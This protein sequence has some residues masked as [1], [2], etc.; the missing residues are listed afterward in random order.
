MFLPFHT[1][2]VSVAYVKE[3]SNAYGIP[4]NNFT[5]TI[6]KGTVIE[7]IEEVDPPESLLPPPTRLTLTMFEYFEHQLEGS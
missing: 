3:S 5:W 7:P 6:D 4:I 1:Y 2:L